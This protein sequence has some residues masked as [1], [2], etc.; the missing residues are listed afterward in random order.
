MIKEGPLEEGTFKGGVED[1]EA[2]ARIREERQ[3]GRTLL[4]GRRKGG[5]HARSLGG[6]PTVPHI[7]RGVTEAESPG[8]AG[9]PEGR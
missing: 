4:G 2:L 9:T 7:F 1:G 3:G 5:V 8:M 6:A